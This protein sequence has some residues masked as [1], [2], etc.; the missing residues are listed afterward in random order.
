MVLAKSHI[1]APDGS[2]ESCRCCGTCVFCWAGRPG[3][4]GGFGESMGSGGPD[5]SARIG[6]SCWS[7]VLTW[8]FQSIFRPF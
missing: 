8:L 2:V 6:G 7:D 5:W 1:L 3:G 4:I